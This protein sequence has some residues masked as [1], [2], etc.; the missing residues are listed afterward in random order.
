MSRERLLSQA[1]SVQRSLERFYWLEQGPDVTEFVRTADG[2]LRESLLVRAEGDAVELALYLPSDRADGAGARD[3]YA[4]LIEG[5]SHFVY[6]AE[7][8]RV[9]LP[10][11]ALELELQA[12]VDKYLLFAHESPLSPAFHPARAVRVREHLFDRVSFLHPAGTEPGDRYRMANDLAARFAG[13]L[14]VSFARRGR[15][16]E[17]R[18]ALRR[19]YFAGQAEKIQLARAA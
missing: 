4:Q 13:R 19:F 16:G 14:E 12:E 15:F 8:A 9:D 5:V 18:D 3:A 7:R 6:V 17:M 10:A 1:R 11:T 2:P